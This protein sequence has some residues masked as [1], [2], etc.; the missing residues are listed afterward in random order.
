MKGGRLTVQQHLR[1]VGHHKHLFEISRRQSPIVS[2]KKGIHNLPEALIT[3]LSA[4][5]KTKNV[6]HFMF[7]NNSIFAQVV[8][9]KGVANFFG[10]RG[11]ATEH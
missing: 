11:S 8:N 10:C 2:R 7:F 3:M 9:F 6:E 5:D 1:R 4:C